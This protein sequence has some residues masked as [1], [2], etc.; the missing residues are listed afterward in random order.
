MCI[1][2]R[3]SKGGWWLEPRRGAP[4]LPALAE[5]VH[6]GAAAKGHVHA[7]ESDELGDPKPSLDRESEH[8]VIAS[9]GPTSLIARREARVEIGDV[10]LAGRDAAA[11]RRELE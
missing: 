4:F 10:E 1:R 8:C 2:D 6:V 3:L 9:A 11:S 5:G 7:V